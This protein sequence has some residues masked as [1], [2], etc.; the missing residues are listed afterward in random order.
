ML[1]NNTISIDE[2]R[3]NLADII[4]RVTYANDKVVVKKYNRNAA[5]IISLSEYEKLMD[6]TKRLSNL[7]W[8]KHVKRLDEFRAKL[9]KFDP[10]E[11]EKAIDEA[12]REVR[13]ERK[14][15]NK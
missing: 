4:N 5:I 11:M 15:K 6:P 9:P 10:E 3:T 1:Q 13:S 7:Q 12:V 8:N 14:L 2:L